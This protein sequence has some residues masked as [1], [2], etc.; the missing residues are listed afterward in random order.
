M[1]NV[2]AVVSGRGGVLRDHA[3]SRVCCVYASVVDVRLAAAAA[4]AAAV[5]AVVVALLPL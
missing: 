5:A 2:V 4:V 3:A 1:V